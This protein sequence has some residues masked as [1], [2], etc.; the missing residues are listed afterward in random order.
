VCC[1]R[2]LKKEDKSDGNEPRNDAYENLQDKD[3][4]PEDDDL[5]DFIVEDDYEDYVGGGRDTA[6]EED[7]DGDGEDFADSNKG[8]GDIVPIPVSL[9]QLG[10]KGLSHFA[11]ETCLASLEACSAPCPQCEMLFGRLHLDSG[12]KALLKKKEEAKVGM[13]TSSKAEDIMDIPRTFYCQQNKGGFQASANHETIEQDFEKVPKNE[14]CIIASFFKSALDLLEGIFHEK[15][16]T[17]A[18]F[19]GDINS[20]ERED[21]LRIFKTRE[22]CRILL[23]TVQTG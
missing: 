13:E 10:A 21:Q 6:A 14:K 8:S 7:V 1:K 9:C 23:M 12:K 3:V 4:P 19:D 11:C 20:D 22:S 2:I 15:G 16:L 18:R 5:A 17:V